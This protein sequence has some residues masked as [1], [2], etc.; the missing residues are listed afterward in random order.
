MRKI[1]AAVVVLAGSAAFAQVDATE[2]GSAVKQQAK[3]IGS[4]AQ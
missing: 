2:V 4:S 3:N 1:L